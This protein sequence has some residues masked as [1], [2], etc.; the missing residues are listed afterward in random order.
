MVRDAYRMNIYFVRDEFDIS[1]IVLSN[2]DI[3]YIIMTKR[4]LQYNRSLNKWKYIKLN[5]T[6]QNPTL[7]LWPKKIVLR[8]H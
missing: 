3:K 1:E 7:E 4:V 6:S 2:E 8:K 5:Y